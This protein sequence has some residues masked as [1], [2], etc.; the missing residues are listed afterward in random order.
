MFWSTFLLQIFS[1]ISFCLK[2]FIKIVRL[3]SAAASINGLSKFSLVG[4]S[5]GLFDGFF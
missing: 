3:L 1:H 5:M 4:S 2:D